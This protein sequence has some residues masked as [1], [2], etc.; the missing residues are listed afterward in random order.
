MREE[1]VFSRPIDQSTN[2][3][4]SSLSIKTGLLGKSGRRGRE[5]NILRCHKNLACLCIEQT[6]VL[7]VRK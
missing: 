7:N 5:L 3:V 2:I 6:F 4:K 1:I